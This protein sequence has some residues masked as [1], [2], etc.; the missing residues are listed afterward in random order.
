M[1]PTVARLVG[2]RAAA[3]PKPVRWFSIPQ[4]FRYERQ[5]RGRLRE[6]YQLNVDLFGEADRLADA[7][8][9]CVA[10]EI[11]R[12]FGLGPD[13]VRARVS[14][15]RL[16]NGLLAHLGVTDEQAPVVYAV[17]D[18]LERQP[19][20][21]SEEK[22]TAV[23]LD[24]SR[25]SAIME[26]GSLDF[27]ATQARY[28]DAPLVKPHLHEFAQYRDHLRAMGVLEFVQFDLTIVR[29]LAYYTGIVFELFDAVGEFRAIC[30]GGRYDTL[31]KS[32]GG[33][34]VPALGF[35]MGDV[36]LG[37]LLRARGK[38]SATIAQPDFWL[39]PDEG[40]DVDTVLR[41]ARALRALDFGVVHLLDADK[42]WNRKARTQL[43]D[44]Q[45]HGAR[46]AMRLVPPQS[47]DLVQFGAREADHR[48]MRVDLAPLFDEDTSARAALTA[49]LRE[50]L[51]GASVPAT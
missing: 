30:G 29:G 41:T 36:V 27:E 46:M 20:P 15:R 26:F 42:L 34:D 2:A 51:A 40:T 5:Q 33:P 37:E 50:A 13:D 21:V 48:W 23:G 28:G 47:A 35:G 7:E 25:V 44:A 8:L 18:K 45:R 43:G 17:L 39:V 16:L 11:M 6:H 31:L 1:T 19:K 10:L 22:L 32:L 38:L 9:L 14:D 12:A 3:L 49:T 24:A 4:L